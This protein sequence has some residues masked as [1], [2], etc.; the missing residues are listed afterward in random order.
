MGVSR[1]A[2]R[3]RSLPRANETVNG[4]SR[5]LRYLDSILND[6]IDETLG[7][8]AIPPWKSDHGQVVATIELEAVSN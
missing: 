5:Y 1:L 8:E 3:F 4:R 6:H 7:D 2:L